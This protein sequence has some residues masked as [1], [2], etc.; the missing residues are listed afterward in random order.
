MCPKS[1]GVGAGAGLRALLPHV[2]PSARAGASWPLLLPCGQHCH[3]GVSP[4]AVAA[5]APQQLPVSRQSPHADF[6]FHSSTPHTAAP[7]LA[8]EA[9]MRTLCRPAGCVLEGDRQVNWM[10]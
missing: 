6:L 2:T 5:Q 3:E 9:T 1:R 7:Q 4:A 8:R 10:Q